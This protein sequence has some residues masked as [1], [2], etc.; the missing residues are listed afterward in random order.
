MAEGQ[1][2]YK[3]IDSHTSQYN[4]RRIQDLLALISM[5]ANKASNTRHITDIRAYYNSVEE[6]YRNVG[7]VI[8]ARVD[9]I[10]QVRNG[11][12]SLLMVVEL[13]EDSR[14]YYNIKQLLG[15]TKQMHWEIMWGLQKLEYFFRIGI[16]NPKGLGNVRF[17]DA[18]VFNPKKRTF[19]HDGNETETEGNSEEDHR[20]T[21]EYP[22]DY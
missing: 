6:L 12:E 7:A 10:E 14:T 22:D 21:E 3:R 9:E 11:Y 4:N 19:D 13:D 5:L 16:R 1:T 18:S 17:Y 20:E 8:S 2:D 15:F